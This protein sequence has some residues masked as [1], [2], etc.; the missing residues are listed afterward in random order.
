MKYMAATHQTI[1]MEIWGSKVKKFEPRRGKNGKG[2]V[3]EIWNPR[4]EGKLRKA[5]GGLWKPI[6][7]EPPKIVDCFHVHLTESSRNPKNCS[8]DEQ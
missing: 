6:R 8:S 7:W 4:G 5:V 3:Y 1:Q 2:F